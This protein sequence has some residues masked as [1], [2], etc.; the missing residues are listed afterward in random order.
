[1]IP[2]LVFVFGTIIGSFLN[3]VILRTGGGALRG[4]SHCPHCQKTLRATELIPLLSFMLQRGR[5]RQCGQKISVQYPIIELATG[6]AAML[7]FTPLPLTASA[8]LTAGSSLIIFAL[9]LILFVID[10]KT[11]LLP[12]LFV[13][14]LAVAV[15]AQ[16]VVSTTHYSASWRTTHSLMGALVGAG[17]LGLLWLITRGQGIGL[18]DVKLMLPLGAL[19][20]TGGTAALL[21]TAFI[22]GG[23][24]ASC[25]LLAR[26]VTAK[27]AVPFGPF[28]AGSAMLFLVY[29]SLLD[30]LLEYFSLRG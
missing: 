12:D 16:L 18:G 11:M 30:K 19:F 3:V 5:C 21:G 26:R 15:V 14:L 6:L 22:V 7:L 2:L 10:L 1:M 4:R 23:L 25:L 24:M 8:W 9:L 17:F 13:V 20:G 29:P 28:L 27:T